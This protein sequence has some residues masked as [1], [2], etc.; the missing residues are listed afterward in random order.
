MYNAERRISAHCFSLLGQLTSGGSSTRRRSG[1]Q[2]NS[3]YCPWICGKA[4]CIARCMSSGL[5]D[6]ANFNFVVFVKPAVIYAKH[7]HL[8]LRHKHAMCNIQCLLRKPKCCRQHITKRH[9]MHKLVEVR[10]GVLVAAAL[11]SRCP[12]AGNSRPWH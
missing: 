7:T 5:A 9:N 12:E 10:D 4:A 3:S 6:T 2:R 8:S 11:A 1:W